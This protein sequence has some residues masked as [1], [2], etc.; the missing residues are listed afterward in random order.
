[1]NAHARP[2]ASLAE[3]NAGAW[4]KTLCEI[5]SAPNRA[6][7]P[8][9][10]GHCRSVR[11]FL[12]H[13]LFFARSQ[14][15]VRADRGH[16]GRGLPPQAF[17][18]PARLRPRLV[19]RP[20]RP[21]RLDGTRHRRADPDALRLLAPGARRSPRLGRQSGRAGCRRHHHAHSLGIPCTFTHQAPR[22]SPVPA[23]AG[24]VRLRPGLALSPQTAPAGRNDERW[25]AAPGSRRW[26]RM[27]R[28][29]CA[30]P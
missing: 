19:L 15:L 2:P 25:G 12:G 30:P 24:D 20:P 22:L 4:L 16:S 14:L 17:H 21:R 7:R 26:R 11:R 27:W 9:A 13:R 23:P 1:M 18:D 8:G 6:Q 3:D 10:S 5:P 29:G 28:S